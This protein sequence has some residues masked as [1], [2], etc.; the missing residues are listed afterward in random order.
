MVARKLLVQLWDQ[1]AEPHIEEVVPGRFSAR[2]SDY[3]QSRFV[4]FGDSV[5]SAID[6]LQGKLDAFYDYI[7]KKYN[8]GP[9]A[10]KSRPLR[11]AATEECI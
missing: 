3:A 6:D 1:E 7:A 2:L 5:D 9:K 11:I 10:D 8:I 4:G